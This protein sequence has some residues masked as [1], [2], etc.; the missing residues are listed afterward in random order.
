MIICAALVLS[1][2]CLLLSV[3]AGAT[4]QLKRQ[5]KLLQE[6]NSL[7]LVEMTANAAGMF[8]QCL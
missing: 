4:F 1:C 7:V 5:L 6:L 2:L 3:D 8:S